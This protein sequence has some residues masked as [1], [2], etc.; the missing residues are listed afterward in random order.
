[1]GTGRSIVSLQTSQ[2]LLNSPQAEA[3]PR[4]DKGN[5]LPDRYGR[6]PYIHPALNGLHGL[7]QEAKDRVL[8]KKRLAGLAERYGLDKVTRWKPRVVCR[9]VSSSCDHSKLQVTQVNN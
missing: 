8:D 4:D 7:S 3:W 6:V 1:M 2:A 5:P 9:S